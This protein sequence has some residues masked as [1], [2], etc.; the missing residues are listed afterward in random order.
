MTGILL[1]DPDGPIFQI[2]L[3]DLQEIASVAPS[4]SSDGSLELPQVH[5]LNCLKDIFINTRLGSSAEAFAMSSFRLSTTCLESDIWA[6]RNCGLMLFRAVMVR[7]S[8]YGG[9]D[10]RHISFERYPGLIEAVA[11][12]LGFD[13]EKMKTSESL[14]ISEIESSGISEERVFPALEL[15]GE[16]LPPH[17]DNDLD[18]LIKIVLSQAGNAIWSVRERVARTFASLV[19]DSMKLDAL[20]KMTSTGWTSENNVHGRLLCLRYTLLPTLKKE[21]K[22]RKRKFRISP[23]IDKN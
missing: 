4:R 17:P 18:F 13:Y 22:D 23:C 15:I 21:V 5:A 14:D 3:K 16:R 9:T 20:F 6:I 2:V 1:S 8:R 12:L 10:P 7:M 19:M 11:N